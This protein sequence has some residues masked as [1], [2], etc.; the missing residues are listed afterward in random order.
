MS[1]ELGVADKGGS[2]ERQKE[3]VKAALQDLQAKVGGGKITALSLLETDVAI[4]AAGVVQEAAADKAAN[5]KKRG[6]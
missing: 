1:I 2:L 5:K 3:A 4:Y 6:K